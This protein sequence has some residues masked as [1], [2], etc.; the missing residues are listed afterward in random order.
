MLKNIFESNIV[1]KNQY[2]ILF[3]NH[4]CVSDFFFVDGSDWV[5][6]FKLS[7]DRG[8]YCIKETRQKMRK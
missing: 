4:K 5:D 2:W 8:G 6:T 7:T 3:L 1:I